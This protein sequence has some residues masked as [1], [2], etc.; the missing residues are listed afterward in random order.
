MTLAP[1]QIE[2]L[3][4]ALALEYEKARDAL[5]ALGVDVDTLLE[6]A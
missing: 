3:R 4:Q 1:A 6:A 2:I 5:S